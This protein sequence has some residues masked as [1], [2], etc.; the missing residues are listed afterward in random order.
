[1]AIITLT[2]ANAAWA[3]LTD[4][5]NNMKSKKTQTEVEAYLGKPVSTKKTG[6]SWSENQ[7]VNSGMA[8]EVAYD[9]TGK[10]AYW[11]CRP[12]PQTPTLPIK[13]VSANS[14]PKSK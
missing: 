12:A 7:Y 13:P 1:M 10:I 3:E 2:M 5:C 11:G 8:V 9:T 6:A 4:V 14:V